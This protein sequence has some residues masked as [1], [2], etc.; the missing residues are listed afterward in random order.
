MNVCPQAPVLASYNAR[1]GS[2]VEQAPQPVARYA[3]RD[4]QNRDRLQSAYPGDRSYGMSYRADDSDD[5]DATSV[6][7]D[8]QMSP[9]FFGRLVG[10]V[11]KGLTKIV[12]NEILREKGG[13]VLGKL[14][15]SPRYEGMPNGS[16]D[17][18]GAAATSFAS[19]VPRTVPA[20][21]P[22]AQPACCGF[23]HPHPA[24][25]G[26]WMNTNNASDAADAMR[27][28][29]YGAA[30]RYDYGSAYARR[31]HGYA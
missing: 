22:R 13:G 29:A 24:G 30:Q 8:A 28:S 31:H 20:Y 19:P 15:E 9:V 18:S 7:N 25:A 17:Q 14:L 16:Y 5:P 6:D 26:E 3:P 23:V 21:A 10:K 11:A 2:H 4:Y 27:S 12:A 1:Y